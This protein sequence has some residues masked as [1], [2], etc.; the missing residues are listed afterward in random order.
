MNRKNINFS[1]Q[2]TKTKTKRDRNVIESEIVRKKVDEWVKG[3]GIELKKVEEDRR[4]ER[5]KE[6]K[7][8]S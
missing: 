2:L 4:R 1:N 8:K 6:L 3:C 7:Q 5:E